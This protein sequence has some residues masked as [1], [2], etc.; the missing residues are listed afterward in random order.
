MT[1]GGKEWPENGVPV[2]AVKERPQSAQRYTCEP[3]RS[4]PFL[5]VFGRSQCGQRRRDSC[6]MGLLIIRSIRHPCRPQQNLF[7]F[8]DEKISEVVDLRLRMKVVEAE[9]CLSPRVLIMAWRGHEAG[10]SVE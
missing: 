2:R 9:L 8:R 10:F 4:R 1:A 7:V 3:R 6:S 5:T